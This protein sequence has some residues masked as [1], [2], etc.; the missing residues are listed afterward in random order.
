MELEYVQRTLLD[1]LHSKKLFQPLILYFSI[2]VYVGSGSRNED[3]Q[4]TGTSYLTQ[5]MILRGTNSHS[6]TEIAEYIENMGG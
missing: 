2:G 6:K 1:K 5:K 4:T 3:L